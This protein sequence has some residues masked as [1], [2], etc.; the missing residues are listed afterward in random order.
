MSNI[1]YPKQTKHGIQRIE[2]YIP[3][4]NED[5]RYGMMFDRFGVCRHWDCSESAVYVALNFC[6]SRG[7]QF[8]SREGTRGTFI[9]MT[10]E[11]P[12]LPDFTLPV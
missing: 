5:N 8:T 4:T 6:R 11:T 10:A 12:Q 3:R 2:V 9:L 7:W 1:W